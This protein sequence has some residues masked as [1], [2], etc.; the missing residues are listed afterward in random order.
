MFGSIS[1]PEVILFLV[2]LILVFGVGRISKIGGELGSGI[3]AFKEG[4]NGKK[5]S[6]E[7]SKSD[8]NKPS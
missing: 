2:V 1:W 8:E 4:L 7:E 6:D 5:E 3:K